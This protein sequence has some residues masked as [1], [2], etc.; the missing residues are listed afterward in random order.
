MLFLVW[1]EIISMDRF[2]WL[3]LLKTKSWIDEKL[4]GRW[5]VDLQRSD[6]KSNSKTKK[7]VPENLGT[8]LIWM[9]KINNSSQVRN[10][11]KNLEN[12]TNLLM[13]WYI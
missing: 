1:F 7:H 6:V 4:V 11:W 5:G 2:H 3:F 8:E 9:E 10:V 13:I 12:G